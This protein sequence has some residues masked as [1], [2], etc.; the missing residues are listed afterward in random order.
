M[1]E[2]INK[3]KLAKYGRSKNVFKMKEIVAGPKKSHQEPHAVMDS[4]TEELVVSTDEIKK[5]HT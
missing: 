1:E 5:G 3:L 4:E 2:E